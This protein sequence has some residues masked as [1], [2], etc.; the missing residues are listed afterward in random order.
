[1]AGVPGQVW[2][3]HQFQ[4]V[5]SYQL[6]LGQVLAAFDIGIDRYLSGGTGSR[7]DADQVNGGPTA[8]FLNV[9]PGFFTDGNPHNATP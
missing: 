3:D 2:R 8:P 4:T 9:F 1:L 6:V 5:L 7:G